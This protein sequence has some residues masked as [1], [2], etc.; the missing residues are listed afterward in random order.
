MTTARSSATQRELARW[1]PALVTALGVLVAWNLLSFAF[2]TAPLE[3][4]RLAAA[5][6]WGTAYGAGQVIFKA[7]P[8]LL[9]GLAFDVAMRA[10]LFNIGAEGQLALA[11]LAAGAVGH[12]LPSGTPAIVA[13]PV[14]LVVA[15]ATGALVALAPALM[16][17]RLGVH[18]IITTIMMNRVVDGLVPF[19]LVALLGARDLRTEPVAA[20]ALVPKLDRALSPL[21]GSAASLAFPLAVAIAFALDAW[22]RRSK[23]GREI[24]W[25]GKNAAACR[26]EGVPVASRLVLA[27]LLSGALAGLVSSATVLGY[28]GYDELGLGAGAGF[29]GIAVALLGRGRPLGLVLAALVL[30]TLEQAGLAINAFVPKEAVSVL[31]AFVIVLMAASTRAFDR[32]AGE[33]A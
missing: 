3:T 13:L 9:T 20:G 17:A 7:T 10:G 4:L 6:S 5:G 19:A 32:P 30:G 28:K 1:A 25:I 12:A 15:A 11:G 31:E 18:E 16:R 21:A 22:Q 2:G 33:R 29:T 23:A 26:A 8:I 27:M 14:V 24:G